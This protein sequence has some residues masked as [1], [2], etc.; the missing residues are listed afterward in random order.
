MGMFVDLRDDVFQDA[1]NSRI[2]IGKT[3]IKKRTLCDL[4]RERGKFRPY[5][6]LFMI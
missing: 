2:Y 4:I 5:S 1:S 3:G 6:P